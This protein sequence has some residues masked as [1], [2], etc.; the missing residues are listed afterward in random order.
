MHDGAA[1]GEEAYTEDSW[2]ASASDPETKDFDEEPAVSDADDP[3][4]DEDQDDDQENAG[5]AWAKILADDDGR[6][7][8]RRE[9]EAE[10]RAT[11]RYDDEAEDNESGNDDPEDEESLVEHS[12]ENEPE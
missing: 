4:A 11:G 1:Y 6:F 10:A 7:D 5:S 3:A 9:L 2:S 12:A 8:D